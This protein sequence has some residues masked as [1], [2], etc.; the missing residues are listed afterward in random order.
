[1]KILLVT[2]QF[3]N[4]SN[5]TVITAQRLA[6]G[7]IKKGHS[8]GVVS[9]SNKDASYNEN[10]AVH[11]YG[12]QA[13]KTPHILKNLIEKQGMVFAK[14]NK[15]VLTKAISKA[16]VVHFIMP[17]YLSRVGLKIAKKQEIPHTAAFHIQPENITYSIGLDQSELATRFLYSSMKNRFYNSFR[18]IHCP[19]EFMANRL[20]EYGYS[21]NLYPISNG[22]DDKFIYYKAKKPKEFQNRFVILMV[23]RLAYEK[24]QD[25]LIDAVRLSK[26]SKKIQLIFAGKGPLKEKYK[27]MGENLINKP[28][29]EFYTQ[30]ELFNVMGFSDLYVHSADVESEAISCIEAFASG[31]VPIIADSPLSA[32]RQ[33]ALDER[34]LFERNNPV[35]LAAKIDYWIE[36]DEARLEM[37][38]QYA[39]HAKQFN[40]SACVDKMVEM[41]EAEISDSKVH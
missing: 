30:D 12:V 5:G 40:H 38:K 13:Y 9:V 27:K 6:N 26:H 19:S 11:N 3:Y 31:L 15:K 32:T 10:I 23:G 24:R 22:V 2:D 35:A 20:K 8:V 21:M 16:D 25:I 28:I 37:E 7:L 41:F 29:F 33:F 4:A 36:H 34:S 39:E 18:H 14:P 1:M 17:F